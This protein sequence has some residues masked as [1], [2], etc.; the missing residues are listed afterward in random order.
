MSTRI[1]PR[2][3]RLQVEATGNVTAGGLSLSSS[4]V[5]RRLRGDW[6][7]VD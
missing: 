5:A 6:Y 3:Q 7:I 4:G 1:G 2:L